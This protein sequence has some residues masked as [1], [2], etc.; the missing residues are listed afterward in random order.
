MIVGIIVLGIVLIF[1]YIANLSSYGI[2][3]RACSRG[4]NSISHFLWTV[5]NMFLFGIPGFVAAAYY[6]RCEGT[7]SYQTRVKQQKNR[8]IPA[9]PAIAVPRT[10]VPPQPPTT[11]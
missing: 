5:A 6:G 2:M 11:S 8:S 7:A 10:A 3:K 4:M 9:N 1:A